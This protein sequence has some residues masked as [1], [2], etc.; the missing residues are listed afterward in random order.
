MI[1][2]KRLTTIKVNEL[3]LGNLWDKVLVDGHAGQLLGWDSEDGYTYVILS[4][5]DPARRILVPTDADIQI[6]DNESAPTRV[7]HFA[8]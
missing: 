1:D 2:A 8:A 5:A 4:P 3:T 6:L 7:T